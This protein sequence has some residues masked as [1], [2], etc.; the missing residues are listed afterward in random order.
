MYPALLKSDPRIGTHLAVPLLAFVALNLLLLGLGGDRWVADR[1][2]ALQGHAWALQHAFVTDGLIHVGGKR[3]SVL[4][5]LAVAGAWG[6]SFRMDSWRP[7]RAPLGRL[8]LSVLVA[9]TLVALLKGQ[10]HMDCPWDLVRYGGDR[11]F[12]GLFQPRPPGLPDGRCFPAGHASA[13]Y[14]WVALYFF[15]AATRPRLRRAGLAFGLVLGGLFGLSQQLRGAHFLSHDL[16]TVA[17][18]WSTAVACHWSVLRTMPARPRSAAGP[19]G[20]ARALPP[21][22][23]HPGHTA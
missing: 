4:A 16:W 9:T 21:P 13:G 15:F 2:Y 11:P 8:A 3:L 1:L 23:W 5:W 12:V 22:A 14:A 20:A 6:L 17:I 7:W 18:C 10:T 19:R